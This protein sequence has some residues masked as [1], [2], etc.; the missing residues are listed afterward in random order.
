MTESSSRLAALI[1]AC[2][3]RLRAF[4]ARRTSAAESED[5][6]Q[7]AIANLLAADR[8]I[9]VEFVAAW[10][11]RAVK[12]ELVDRRR[13][14]R[15]IQLA[16]WDEGDQALAEM[17]DVMSSQPDN[18]EEAYL[19]SLFWRELNLALEELPSEQREAFVRTELEGWSFKKLAEDTGLNQNTLLSRKCRAVRHLRLRL[20]ACYDELMNC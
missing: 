9:R 16:D 18:P 7:E 17:S 1:E 3:G 14:I 2:R 11:F 19:H 4:A 12:N 6:V 5:V 8:L 15:E 13:K 10:L 20:K